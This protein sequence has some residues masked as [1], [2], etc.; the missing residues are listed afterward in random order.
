MNLWPVGQADRYYNLIIDEIEFVASNPLTG[1]SIDH[2]K[3]G[4]R[5]SKVKSHRVFYKML[6]G[7]NILVVRILH[8]RM[9]IKN[10][11]K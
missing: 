10:R 5:S 6:D 11:M 9:D 3:Q 1:K 8:Q 4:Y 7:D 2:I